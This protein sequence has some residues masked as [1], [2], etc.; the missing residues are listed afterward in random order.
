MEAQPTALDLSRRAHRRCCQRSHRK[1]QQRRQPGAMTFARLS[2]SFD[3]AAHPRNITGDVYS[4][5]NPLN[6]L[7][8]VLAAILLAVM[9]NREWRRYAL[10]RDLAAEGKLTPPSVSGD[11][12]GD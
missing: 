8:S 12:R 10:R 11:P 6:K 5:E 9:Q 1:A 7:F 4:V 3:G 2:A